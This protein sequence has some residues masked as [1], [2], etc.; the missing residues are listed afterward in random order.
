MRLLLFLFL[1]TIATAAPP[2]WPDAVIRLERQPAGAGVPQISTALCV[3]PGLLATI[4]DKADAADSFRAIT[5][6]GSTGGSWSSGGLGA[7]ALE[8]CA[9]V[10][11][12]HAA[13]RTG[14]LDRRDIDAG[15]LGD[16][17]GERRGEYAV[18]T[19]PLPCPV[20]LCCLSRGGGSL[21][22]RC[23]CGCRPSG[24]CSR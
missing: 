6:G 10:L 13:M 7:A 14:T 9:H 22:R 16:A 19:S 1:S 15:V 21:R 5:R 12:D 3:A 8:G 23:G 11:L 20:R 18:S 4:L 2:A 24:V 17:L